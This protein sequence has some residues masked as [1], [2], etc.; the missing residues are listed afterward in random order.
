MR[1][2]RIPAVVALG[3]AG[4]RAASGTAD[5]RVALRL[6]DPESLRL[7]LAGISDANTRHGEG[8]AALAFSPVGTRLASA[9]EDGSIVLWNTSDGSAVGPVFQHGGGRLAALALAPDGRTVAVAGERGARIWDGLQGVPGPMLGA[10]REVTAVALDTAGNRAFTGTPEGLVE[11][12][13]VAG[14]ERLWFGALDAPV[15][16]IALSTEGT[17]VAAGGATGLVRAWG[18]GP[19]GRAVSLALAAPVLHLAFS[20]DGTALLAQTPGWL[21]RL[22]LEEGRLLVLSSRML[23]ASVPPAGWRS[24]DAAGTRVALVG[25]A[26]GET[27]AVLDF[28]RTEPP[29]EDW[30]VDLEAWQARLQLYFDA[31]G[32]LRQDP[33]GADPVGE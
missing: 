6:R 4:L 21:H 23:P 33:A 31:E 20:P 12:W 5:G 19:A 30:T 3:P 25:G 9:G 2:P 16:S 28:A 7:H 17:A 1:L 27:M 13:G 32:E 10:G 22:G 14:G 15:D 26:H 8:V 29:P 18:M 24:A 11:S